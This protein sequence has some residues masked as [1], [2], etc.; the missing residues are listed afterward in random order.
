MEGSLS[1]AWHPESLAGLSCPQLPQVSSPAR[2]PAGELPRCC[3]VSG[4][5]S[6]TCDLGGFRAQDRWV[7]IVRGPRGPP[8]QPVLIMLARPSL[9]APDTRNPPVQVSVHCRPC[10]HMFLSSPRVVWALATLG[11]SFRA[12][13]L[14][15]SPNLTN[16]SLS[17]VSASLK[18][19]SFSHL[20]SQLFGD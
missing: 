3:D 5:A 19:C 7:W 15:C 10:Q 20:L 8:F 2:C 16:Q 11:A 18:P 14:A 17:W 1:T 9:A 4:G 13:G 6:R 12:W